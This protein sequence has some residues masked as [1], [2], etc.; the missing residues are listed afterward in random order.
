MLT[1][2]ARRPYQRMSS[3]A[4]GP[5]SLSSAHLVHSETP[6][7]APPPP[8]KQATMIESVSARAWDVEP[9]QHELISRQETPNST[10]STLRETHTP[11]LRVSPKRISANGSPT[12]PHAGPHP[13]RTWPDLVAAPPQHSAYSKVDVK[14]QGPAP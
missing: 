7:E 14:H 11:D 2:D 10:P 4:I 6:L 12:A 3:C 1:L 8:N 13:G 5:S 9:A